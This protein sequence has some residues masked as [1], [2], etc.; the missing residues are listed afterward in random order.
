M[1]VALSSEG[2]SLDSQ[3]SGVFA[4]CPYFVVAEVKNQKIGAIQIIENK[5]LDQIGGAGIAIAKLMAEKNVDVV[6][7]GNIGPRA[8]EILRQFGIEIYLG[9]GKI[10]EVLQ[11]FIAGKLEKI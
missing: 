4:R 6:V 3:V 9:Q 10:K 5:R 2:K 8:L 11:E 7:T 1:K